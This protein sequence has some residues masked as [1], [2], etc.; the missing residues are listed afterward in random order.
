[1]IRIADFQTIQCHVALSDSFDFIT[2]RVSYM[3]YNYTSEIRSDFCHANISY[4]T[5]ADIHTLHSCVDDDL[6]EKLESFVCD[7]LS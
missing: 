7:F 2:F 4:F 1:M 3:L 6:S 5:M